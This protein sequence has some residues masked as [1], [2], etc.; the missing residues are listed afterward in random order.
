MARADVKADNLHA[1]RRHGS[2]CARTYPDQRGLHSHHST[3]RLS[4]SFCWR[5]KRG[6]RHQAAYGALPPGTR[7]MAVFLERLTETSS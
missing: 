5:L 7:R 6:Y 2:L 3:L 1:A 4:R